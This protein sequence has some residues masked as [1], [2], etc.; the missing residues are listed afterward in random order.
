MNE[1]FNVTAKAVTPVVTQA[2][3]PA[4]IYRGLKSG[5]TSALGALVTRDFWMDLGARVIKEMINAFMKTLGSKFLTYGSS[6]E[7]PEVKRAA[8]AASTGGS[9]AFSSSQSQSGYN[10]RFGNESYR[11]GYGNYPSVMTPAPRNEEKFPGF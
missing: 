7:D 10:S 3:L 1:V 11:S 6:R 9:S 5:I 2:S 8:Q 4:R